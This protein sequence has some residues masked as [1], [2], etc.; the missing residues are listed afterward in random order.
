MDGSGTFPVKLQGC[1][2][3]IAFLT[4]DFCTAMAVGQFSE[5][6]KRLKDC[7]MLSDQSLLSTLVR[8]W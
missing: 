2:L 4:V 6:E 5:D 3:Y 1:P 8:C 7:P